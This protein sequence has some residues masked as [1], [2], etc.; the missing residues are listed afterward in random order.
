MHVASMT[1]K[2]YRYILNIMGIFLTR[3]RINQSAANILS[4]FCETLMLKCIY[5]V[6]I[7]PHSAY[8]NNNADKRNDK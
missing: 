8:R 1:T 4:P 5:Y 7:C 3:L 6:Y 2:L